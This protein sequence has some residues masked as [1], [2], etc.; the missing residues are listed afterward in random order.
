MELKN[1]EKNLIKL[2]RKTG[3]GE[4][5]I[6][7]EGGQPRRVLLIEK[8]IHLTDTIDNEIEVGIFRVDN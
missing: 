1:T 6:K 3:Y 2:I 4:M 8:S 5:T 7:I